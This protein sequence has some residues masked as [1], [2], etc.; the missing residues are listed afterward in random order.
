MA[1]QIGWSPDASK[2]AWTVHNQQ[3]QRVDLWIVDYFSGRKEVW[4]GEK[5]YQSTIAF[6]NWAPNGKE[7]TFQKDYASE[8]ELWK[9]SNFQPPAQQ[10]II[11]VP[12]FWR[13]KSPVRPY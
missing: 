4:P 5:D 13:S 10:R 9:L 2:L 12:R 8:L 7:I 11:A 3:A 6:P 1:G